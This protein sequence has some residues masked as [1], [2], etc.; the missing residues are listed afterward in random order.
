MHVAQSQKFFSLK[1]SSRSIQTTEATTEHIQTTFNALAIR[2]S[3]RIPA[4]YITQLITIKFSAE[5][6]QSDC[7][8]LCM[9][10]HINQTHTHTGT[11]EWRQRYL[12]ASTADQE[13][14]GQKA[15]RLQVLRDLQLF[16]P[17]TFSL[18]TVT[19]AVAAAAAAAG[20]QSANEQERRQINH[21]NYGDDAF[22]PVSCPE[23]LTTG[24]KEKKRKILMYRCYTQPQLDFNKSYLVCAL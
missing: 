6:S 10:V 23:A 14:G 5:T 16:D 9:S 19:S 7:K 24:R 12:R 22:Q 13:F 8:H 18:P 3:S 4:D 11:L 2:S 17:G 20:R 15:E 1:K 21:F